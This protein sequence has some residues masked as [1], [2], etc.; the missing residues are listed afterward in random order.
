MHITKRPTESMVD[1]TMR[2]I[3]AEWLSEV[4]DR[5]MSI[6]PD[7]SAIGEQ[8]KIGFRSGHAAMRISAR[9]L[10]TEMIEEA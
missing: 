5:L 8:H 9:D 6:E 7:M 10:L 2:R 3:R 4:R 1:F